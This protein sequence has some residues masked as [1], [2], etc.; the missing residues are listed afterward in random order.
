VGTFST[1]AT[2]QAARTCTRCGVVHG[3]W[4]AEIDPAGTVVRALEIPGHHHDASVLRNG[5]LLVNAAERCRP[6]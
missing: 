6:G 2:C 5:N 1:R 4:L 3:G